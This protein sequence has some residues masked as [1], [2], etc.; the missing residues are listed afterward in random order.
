M[1]KIRILL[2][3]LFLAVLLSG[4]G[5]PAPAAETPTPTP[6]DEAILPLPTAAVQGELADAVRALL[7]RLQMFKS[8]PGPRVELARLGNEAVI[9]GAA[10]LGK[11]LYA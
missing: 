7:P 4:C 6:A 2:G 1:K 9:I 5:G 11:N 3:L 10:L 8:V